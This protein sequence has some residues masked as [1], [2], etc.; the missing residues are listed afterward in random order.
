MAGGWLGG[1]RR[2]TSDTSKSMMMEEE[3]AAT[4]TATQLAGSREMDRL[5]RWAI[6]LARRRGGEIE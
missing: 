3:E 4:A 2:S 1:K 6:E 5:R